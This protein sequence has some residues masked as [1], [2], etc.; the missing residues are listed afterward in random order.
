MVLS[1][2]TLGESGKAE[3]QASKDRVNLSK[4]R[5]NNLG[6]SNKCTIFAADK[7]CSDEILRKKALL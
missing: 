2:A 6:V 7:L 4:N 5:T 3:R 1:V